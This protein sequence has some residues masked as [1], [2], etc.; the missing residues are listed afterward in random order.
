MQLLVS[1]DFMTSFISASRTTQNRGVTSL[2]PEPTFYGMILI[3]YAVIF[4]TI[5]IKNKKL[6]I[7]LCAVSVFVLAQSS[8]S[9]LFL[10][11]A[12]FLYL[13]LNFNVKYFFYFYFLFLL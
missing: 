6:F 11:I 7:F 8:M 13:I 10:F 1:S 12:S 3:F 9:I 2:A 5:E 4:S